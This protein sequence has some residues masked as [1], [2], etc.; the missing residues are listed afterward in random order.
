MAMVS[1]LQVYGATK[2]DL[3][4]HRPL[5]KLFAF[6]AVV[7]LTFIQTVCRPTAHNS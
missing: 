7:G 4:R 6:K 3:A 5:A 1:I 2:I